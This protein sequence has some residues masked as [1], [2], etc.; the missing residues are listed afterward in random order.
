MTLNCTSTKHINFF[1]FT[2][3]TTRPTS[4]LSGSL[5]ALVNKALREKL[6][7]I[8]R[9]KNWRTCGRIR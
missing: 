5:Q 3:P 9:E 4:N 1:A 6:N 8:K 7:W 2:S